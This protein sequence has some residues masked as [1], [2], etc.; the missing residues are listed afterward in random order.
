MF[1]KHNSLLKIKNT[2]Y[3]ATY[4]IGDLQ[5]C[6]DNL[7]QLLN[8]IN[9]QPQHDKVW[10]VGDLVNRGHD[11]L[12][13]LRYVKNLGTA[14]QTVLGNHDLHLLAI[15]HNL[16]HNNDASIKAILDAPDCDELMLWLRN[17]PLLHYDEQ[18]QFT[19]VHAGIYPHWNLPQAKQYANELETVLRSDNYLAFLNNMYGDLPNLW[20]PS[21][22]NWERLRFICNSFTRMRYCTKDGQLDFEFNGA[23][24]S[25]QNNLIPWFDVANR[26]KIKTKI[27]FGHWSTLGYYQEQQNISL[28]ANIFAIDTGCVWGG[29]LTALKIPSPD[30]SEH[31][32]IISVN[33]PKQAK[34]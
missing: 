12:R 14:A 33:C 6:Y 10:F 19:M 9:F 27:V 29:K 31:I 2:L 23:P 3:M 8:K 26:A 25:Q 28:P 1:L 4:V 16:K 13:T 34:K 15:Y 11:S 32:E 5:G 30:K 18:S 22:S 17:R 24:G 21:L 20:Q 7:V